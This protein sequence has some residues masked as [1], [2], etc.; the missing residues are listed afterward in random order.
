MPH[1][2]GGFKQEWLE[3]KLG[4]AGNDEEDMGLELGEQVGDDIGR[5]GGGRGRMRPR[6][7]W[8]R[9]DMRWSNRAGACVG[10]HITSLTT[11][12]CPR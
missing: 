11:F 4:G 1:T 5:R 12:L 3:S 8:S 7:S 10:N 2:Q 6:A 9:F